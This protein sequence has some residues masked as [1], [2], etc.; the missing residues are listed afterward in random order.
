MSLGPLRRSRTAVLGV[1]IFVLVLVFYVPWELPSSVKDRRIPGLSRANVAQL[2]RD[3]KVK[4]DELYGLLRVVTSQD[5]GNTLT[6]NPELDPSSPINWDVYA[7]G[8]SSV[9]WRKEVA[10]LNKEYPV[11][12]FSKTYCPYSKRA[13]QLLRTYKIRPPPKVI[14][15]DT[16]SDGDVIKALLTRLTGHS[17]FPNVII[18]GKSIGGSDNLH[19]LHSSGNLEKLIKDTGAKVKKTPSNPAQ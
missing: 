3:S 10:R 14:E 11:I 18:Q 7:A 16:R 17:T 1:I 6:E 9:N 12:V 19:E 2:A 4:V 5:T 15:V 8:D 13:K